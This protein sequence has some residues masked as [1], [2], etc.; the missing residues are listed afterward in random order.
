MKAV[1]VAVAAAGL[2]L[3]G[4]SGKG[5]DN[6]ATPANE[7]MANGAIDNAA[8]APAN[9]AAA[10]GADNAV[11]GNAVDGAALESGDPESAIYGDCYL[12]VDGKV[13]L[14]IRKD[15]PMVSLHDGQGSLILNSDGE[16][17]IKGI[18]AY[19]TPNGDGTASASWNE[20][21]GVTHA[22][23]PLSEKLKRDGA[24]W[25]D[26]RVKICATKR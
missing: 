9:A 24:C 12:R 6:G 15:C 19:L 7:A 14:D 18:F 26:E 17:E 23:A 2:L 3:G 1:I 4:C 5:G 25:A 8:D 22:Q 16:S 13:V 11:A 20:E 21:P 10:T